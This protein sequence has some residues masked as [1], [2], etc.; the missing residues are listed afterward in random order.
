M[1]SHFNVRLSSDIQRLYNLTNLTQPLP[2]TVIVGALA[3]MRLIPRLPPKCHFLLST[4]IV[5]APFNFSGTVLS[6]GAAGATRAVF[7]RLDLEFSPG[8]GGEH[9][10]GKG[11]WPPPGFGAPSVQSPRTKE[12]PGVE[13]RRYGRGGGACQHRDTGRAAAGSQR[14]AYSPAATDPT[15]HCH[16]SRRMGAR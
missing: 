12:K 16:W 10:K 6:M 2:S 13:L 9:W 1:P 14:S 3:Q 15:A 11:L 4:N 5:Q 8:H 7:F